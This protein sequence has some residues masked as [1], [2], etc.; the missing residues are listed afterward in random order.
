MK[1]PPPVSRNMI[2]GWK[3]IAICDSESEHGCLLRI[4]YNLLR[5]M[6][7]LICLKN[8]EIWVGIRKRNGTSPI[9]GEPDGWMDGRGA[10]E[11]GRTWAWTT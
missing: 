6:T 3:R 10:N 2:D 11:S 8:D 4:I 7:R 9:G 1:I 5:R